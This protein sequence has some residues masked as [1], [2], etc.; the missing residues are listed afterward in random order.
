VETFLT[1]TTALGGIATGI[2]AI[3]ATLAARRQAQ[4]GER[5]AQLT[6]RSLAEQCRILREQNAKK[7]QERGEIRG[8]CPLHRSFGIGV[9]TC[10]NTVALGM[11]EHSKEGSTERERT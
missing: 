7:R 10:A 3:L 5:Q 1:L 2:G 6:E 9:H 8:Q 4:I 11:M